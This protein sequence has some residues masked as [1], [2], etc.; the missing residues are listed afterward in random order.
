[1]TT[2]FQDIIYLAFM[3]L[4]FIFWE[5]GRWSVFGILKQ[6]HVL[7]NATHLADV[8]SAQDIRRIRHS[9][10]EEKADNKDEWEKQRCLHNKQTYLEWTSTWLCRPVQPLAKLHRVYSQE[11]QKWS[12]QY[13]AWGSSA[14]GSTYFKGCPGLNIASSGPGRC[15]VMAVVVRRCTKQQPMSNVP[16]TTNT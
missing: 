9:I 12:T 2:G 13:T 10:C 3:A 15:A 1:M 6:T 8:C 4:F 5:G 11:H 7:C 16:Q 14:H